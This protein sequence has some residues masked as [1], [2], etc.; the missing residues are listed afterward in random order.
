MN[1]RTIL[2]SLT[3][4]L[5]VA[6]LF[7]WISHAVKRAEMIAPVDPGFEERVAHIFSGAIGAGDEVIDEDYN[8]TKPRSR[9]RRSMSENNRGALVGKK[10]VGSQKI[11]LSPL[12]SFFDGGRINFNSQTINNN[13][14]KGADMKEV[15][16]DT[17]VNHDKSHIIL[18]EALSHILGPAN[19]ELTAEDKRIHDR[20]AVKVFASHAAATHKR[21][22]EAMSSAKIFWAV[23]LSL[24]GILFT[25]GCVFAVHFFMTNYT[26]AGLVRLKRKEGKAETLLMNR[27]TA[28][29]VDQEDPPTPEEKAAEKRKAENQAILAGLQSLRQTGVVIPPEIQEQIRQTAASAPPAQS[30]SSHYPSLTKFQ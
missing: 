8:D 25:A 5:L 22:S 23:L 20:D 26:V 17:I 24:L 28:P 29:E 12:S 21:H 15:G 16:L 7:F 13:A 10:E 14:P 19:H 1:M 4:C 30:L 3:V 9:G 27:L 2:P 11:N 18:A 6:A